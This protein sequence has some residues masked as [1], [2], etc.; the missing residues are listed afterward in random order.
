MVKRVYTQDAQL[1]RNSCCDLEVRSRQRKEE[2]LNQISKL[3]SGDQRVKN[4]RGIHT[5]GGGKR[6]KAGTGRE[7]KNIDC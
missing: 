3:L 2:D 5:R 7:G 1:K 6:K 4:Q